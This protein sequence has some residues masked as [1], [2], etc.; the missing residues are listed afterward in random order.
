MC[1][2]YIMALTLVTLTIK[3]ANVKVNQF[4]NMQINLFERETEC[5]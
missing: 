1:I 5:V 3:V 4:T 2:A